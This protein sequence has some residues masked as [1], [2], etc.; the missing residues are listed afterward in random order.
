[1]GTGRMTG[2]A[3][4]LIG[5]FGGFAI[6]A[7]DR[8]APGRIELRQ[9]GRTFAFC[10]DHARQAIEYGGGRKGGKVA[11]LELAS[12]ATRETLASNLPGELSPIGDKRGAT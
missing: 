4:H 2:E 1:M 11:A 7:D 10:V 8:L 5:G 9:G 6:Y 12:K 3:L